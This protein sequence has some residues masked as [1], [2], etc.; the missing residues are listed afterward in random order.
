MIDVDAGTL[1]GSIV[2][3][4]E[5][6]VGKAAEMCVSVGEEEQPA[7]RTRQLIARSP[8]APLAVIPT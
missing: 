5:L 4:V 2:A 6:A 1:D 8:L 3:A 7:T